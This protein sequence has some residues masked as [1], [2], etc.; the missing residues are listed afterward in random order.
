MTNIDPASFA[1]ATQRPR[2]DGWTPDRQRLF[3]EALAEWGSVRLAAEHVGMSPRTA[4]RLRLHPGATAF[5]KAWD[6]ALWAS[7]TRLSDLAM[8][9]VRDGSPKTVWYKGEAVG[10]ERVL[11]DRLLMFMLSRRDPLRYEKYTEIWE[12]DTRKL[13]NVDDEVQRALGTLDQANGVAGPAV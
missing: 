9:R 4:Y 5:A 11:N 6:A 8:E 2:T 7:G 1:P 10:E 13:P 12:I 3:I